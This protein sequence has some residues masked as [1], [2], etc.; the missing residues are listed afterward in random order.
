MR[1]AKIFRYFGITAFLIAF[2]GIAISIAI[3]PWFK[4]T[5]NALS[6]LGRVGLNNNYI[7][8]YT[9]IISSIFAMFFSLYLA[10]IFKSKI[11][12]ISLG[13]YL[14]AV[15]HLA[16]TGLFPEGTKPHG[17]VSYEFFALM[18]FSLLFFGVSF[19]TERRART[20]S[21]LVFLFLL[22]L[23]GS[24]LIKWPSVATLEIYNIIIYF[25][26]TTLI[27]ATS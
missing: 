3:N 26:G 11:G 21:A 25:A 18:T 20:G 4:L 17:F 2:I 24:L 8:N 10:N 19:L 13:V 14:V 23:L 6:D 12:F 5:S 9:L 1:Y 15:A 22:S 27:S 7:F 16:M